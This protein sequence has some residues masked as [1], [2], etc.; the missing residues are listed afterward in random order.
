MQTQKPYNWF[1]PISDAQADRDYTEHLMFYREG[2]GKEWSIVNQVMNEIETAVE[3]GMSE[4]Y[5]WV[6]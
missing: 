2:L 6:Y 4:D 5:D 1:G 3:C